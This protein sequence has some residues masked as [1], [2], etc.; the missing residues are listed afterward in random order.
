MVSADSGGFGALTPAL[1][2]ENNAR[3]G[4]GPKIMTPEVVLDQNHVALK[5]GG[6]K[7]SM[8]MADFGVLT[9]GSASTFFVSATWCRKHHRF[10]VKHIPVRAL[11]H[12]FVV[13]LH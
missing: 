7:Q 5:V 8:D 13:L 10:P 12:N 1:I 4:V 9:T 3:G 2:D 6:V 11:Q